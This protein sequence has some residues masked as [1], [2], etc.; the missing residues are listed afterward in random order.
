MLDVIFAVGAALYLKSKQ[1][2]EKREREYARLEREKRAYMQRLA[3][4]K[5]RH[6]EYAFYQEQIHAHHSAVQVANAMY[7]LYQQGKE[8]ENSV[9]QQLK[10]QGQVIA[11]LKQQRAMAS[12]ENKRVIVEQ[13]QQVRE[14][15]QRLKDELNTHRQDNQVLLADVR[16]LNA[17]AREHKEFIRLNTGRFGREWYARLEQRKNE[18]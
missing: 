3:Q 6:D 9:S 14:I 8:M 4:Q 7:K 16:A 1:L 17:K 10:N 15:F 18:R 13:L 11:D 5:R 12:G 2:S